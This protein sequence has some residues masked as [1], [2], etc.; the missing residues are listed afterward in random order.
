[1]FIFILL[2]I[3]NRFQHKDAVCYCPLLFAAC[4]GGGEGEDFRLGIFGKSHTNL[5]L[6]S[7]STRGQVYDVIIICTFCVWAKP[8]PADAQKMCSI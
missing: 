6:L 7:S 4:Y 2:T 8:N 3:Y 5:L 1:M